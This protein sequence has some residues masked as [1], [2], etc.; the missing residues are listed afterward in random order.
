M[1]AALVRLRQRALAHTLFSATTLSE[2]L[3][4][5]PFVQADPIRAPARAQDLILRQRVPGY[6]VGDLERAYAELDLDEGIL[7][8]YGFL[9]RPLWQLLHPPD[10]ARLSAL[11][12]KVLA[13]VEALGVTH[14]EALRVELGR[15]S[16]VNAWGGQSS[17]VK[18]ALESLHGRGL[19]RV[20]R[21]EKGVRLYAPCPA[22]DEALAP[23]EVFAR[24]ALA[25]AR[26]LAPTPE[27]TL[28]AIMARLSRRVP[29]LGSPARELARLVEQGALERLIVDDVAYLAPG[30]PSEPPTPAPERRVRFL[31]PFD[32]LVWDRQRFE[33]LWGWPY[34]F[35]AYTPVAQRVRGYYAMPLCHGHDV[36][37]WAN[38][39]AR[40][41]ALE[42]ELGFVRARPRGRDFTRELEAEVERLRACLVAAPGAG[43]D[44]ASPEPLPVRRSPQ[45]F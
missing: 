24:L 38:V 11:E 5:L 17:R 43:G 19:V 7:Y 26:V 39:G 25:V 32:P 29:A 41:A 14:P 42:L 10:R 22:P 8:A 33:H 37:G 28:R 1:R 12:K 27:R 36:I 30:L 15:R 31:A 45:V 13:R 4:R 20:A 9:P 16:A 23:A 40:G 35:E 21:R 6:R 44:A 34:R 2:A 3:V 18:L